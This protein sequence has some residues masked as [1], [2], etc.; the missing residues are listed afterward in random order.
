MKYFK[1]NFNVNSCVFM[2][3]LQTM[4]RLLTQ[5]ACFVAGKTLSEHIQLCVHSNFSNGNVNKGN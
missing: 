4:M 3:F 2:F 5:I 1:S